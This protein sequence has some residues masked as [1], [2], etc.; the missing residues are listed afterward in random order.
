MLRD[1]KK[2]I[3]IVYE[4]ISY[5]KRGTLRKMTS[6]MPVFCIFYVVRCLLM[7]SGHSATINFYDKLGRKSGGT[8]WVI[9]QCSNALWSHV[10]K[11]TNEDVVYIRLREKT[12]LRAVHFLGCSPSVICFNAPT[13]FRRILRSFVSRKPKWLVKFVTLTKNQENFL[14]IIN[15]FYQT[16]F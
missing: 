9:I 16:K 11:G 13:S 10:A 14:T 12:L 6:Q 1:K 3:Y 15:V 8:R 2:R 7:Q 5:N 4:H